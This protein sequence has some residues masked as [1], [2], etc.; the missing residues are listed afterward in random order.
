MGAYVSQC[1]SV[2]VVVVVFAQTGKW[3]SVEKWIGRKKM[4]DFRLYAKKVAAEIGDRTGQDTAKQKKKTK[5]RS[6]TVS[7]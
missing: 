5:E 7:E 4:V 1:V 2:V 3:S 6:T